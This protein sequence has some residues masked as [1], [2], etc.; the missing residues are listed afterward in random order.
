MDDEGEEFDDWNVEKRKWKL[1]REWNNGHAESRLLW[2]LKESASSTH[3][4]PS[5]I[6]RGWSADGSVGGQAY[7]DPQRLVASS[8]HNPHPIENK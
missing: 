3:V 8:G 5:I 1:D 4:L 2:L 7:R 6:H